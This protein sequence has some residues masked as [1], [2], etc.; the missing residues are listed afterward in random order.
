MWC[1]FLIASICKCDRGDSLAQDNVGRKATGRI[2][3]CNEGIF[4]IMRVNKERSPIILNS[5]NELYQTWQL[6]RLNKHKQIE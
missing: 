6:T 5:C 3:I 2:K 1:K 4:L